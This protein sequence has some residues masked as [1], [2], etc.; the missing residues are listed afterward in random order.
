MHIIELYSYSFLIMT[1]FGW[2]NL[3]PWVHRSPVSW[4]SKQTARVHGTEVTLTTSVCRFFSLI[5]PLSPARWTSKSHLHNSIPSCLGRV[6]NLMY[7]W[8][9]S[10]AVLSSSLVA[11]EH[12]HQNP[13]FIPIH[14]W[15]DVSWKWWETLLRNC[16]ASKFP[17][18]DDAAGS[19]AWCS[20]W[21]NVLW[22]SLLSIEKSTGQLPSIWW[23]SKG[24]AS[25]MIL[26]LRIST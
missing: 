7:S 11:L 17:M 8:V 13:S 24:K 22:A 2:E 18:L 26:R 4:K 10:V 15:V 9:L 14:W 20:S 25:K 6:Q 23:A 5:G 12:G 1:R 21:V 19:F 16:V 3:S